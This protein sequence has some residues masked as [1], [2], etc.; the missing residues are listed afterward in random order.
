MR[1]PFTLT[2]ADDELFVRSSG[3]YD[4]ERKIEMHDGIIV[5]DA[6]MGTGKTSML[7][8]LSKRYRESIFYREAPEHERLIK[9]VWKNISGFFGRFKKPTIENILEK[10]GKK[11]LLI[12]VDEAH[13][14]SVKCAETVKMISEKPS[15]TIVLSGVNL[16]ETLNDIEPALV[17]RIVSTISLKGMNFDEMKEM[18]VK[19]IENTDVTI[20]DGALK[21]IYGITGGHPREVLKL[22]LRAYEETK[23][24][25]RAII[26]EIV[27]DEK[28]EE[29][30]PSLTPTQN[31]IIE[32]I[33][34]K[35]SATATE[36]AKELGKS[37]R[38]ISVQLS[39]MGDLL[40][41]KKEGKGYR[42]ILRGNI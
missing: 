10:L 28:K 5:I 3:M 16:V 23:D 36:I 31:A 39:K 15:T 32:Y 29:E 38:S 33:R 37:R 35:G 7:L 4:I 21:A 22:C 20:S 34:E 11:R 27:E 6:P 42:Y 24:I 17:D 8:Y 13:G 40:E 19:R 25:S 26:E 12:L 1:N 41:R 30:T 2:P 9:D 18:V 14:L